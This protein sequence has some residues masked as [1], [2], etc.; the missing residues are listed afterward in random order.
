MKPARGLTVAILVAVCLGGGRGAFGQGGARFSDRTLFVHF[1]SHEAAHSARQV[2]PPLLAAIGARVEWASDIVPGLAVVRVEDPRLLDLAETLTRAQADVL[3][4]ERDPAIYP[5]ASPNDQPGWQTQK[6]YMTR[7]CFPGAWNLGASSDVVLAVLD[8]GVDLSMLEM[9]GNLLTNTG[10]PPTPNGVD[11]DH[12]GYVDDYWGTEFLP[13]GDP[14]STWPLP[15]DLVGHGNHVASVLAAAG[16]NG[17]GIAGGLWTCAYI[18]VKI[19]GRLLPND[20]S[21]ASYALKGMEYAH[22]R[23]ARIVNCSWYTMVYSAGL[24]KM[25]NH[26]S[27]TLYV[28][29]AGNFGFSLDKPTRCFDVYPAMFDTPNMVCVGASTPDD[30]MWE[31]EPTDCARPGMT[32]GSCWGETSVDLFAPGSGITVMHPSGTPA[33]NVLPGQEGTS[34]AAPLVSAAAALLWTRHTTWTPLQVK[35]QLLLSVDAVFPGECVSGGRL[36]VAAALGVPCE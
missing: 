8:G 17:Q 5:L 18:P 22:R 19:L 32:F 13:P 25:M 16:N 11:D 24:Y 10:E 36:N 20:P 29:G 28:V 2:T 4:T 6:P 35:S 31:L 1:T 30:A 15:L 26:N 34:L 21:F 14:D 33:G 9:Q 12:N 23:G 7:A 27:D 3:A